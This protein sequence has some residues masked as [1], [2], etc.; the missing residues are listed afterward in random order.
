M[1][2][3]FLSLT[4]ELLTSGWLKHDPQ[5]T[6]AVQRTIKRF[7]SVVRASHV[8]PQKDD[9]SVR[10]YDIF[11]STTTQ[12]P[13]SVVDIN[14]FVRDETIV[15]PLRTGP[16]WNT[17][18]PPLDFQNFPDD[19]LP[20]P[21]H[22]HKLNFTF[23]LPLL[24]S[25]PPPSPGFAQRLHLEAI[26]AGLRVVCTAEDRSL[27]FYRIFNRVLDLPTRQILKSMMIDILDHNFN[28]LLLPPP[29]SD[30]DTSWAGGPASSPWLHASDVARYFRTIGVDLDQSQGI[31]SVK[32]HSGSLVARL[33]HTR[34]LDGRR[35]PV[36]RC[37][38]V[39]E[40]LGP[41]GHFPS[42]DRAFRYTTTSQCRK[43]AFAPDV[44]AN[45][46][47][48]NLQNCG[49]VH[50]SMDVSRLI[51]GK[52]FMGPLLF[53]IPKTRYSPGPSSVLFL[54]RCPIPVFTSPRSLKSFPMSFH[55][56]F[57]M[58]SLL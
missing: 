34:G 12:S 13:P 24:K 18:L 28:Q 9:Q 50:I 26:R 41:S 52:Y 19:L 7:I 46:L 31:V 32:V 45:E 8:P 6:K 21:H 48:P 47:A 51:Y 42:Q 57:P 37:P 11:D 36:Q 35:G 3:C 44:F 43:S 58:C 20:S 38:D 4:D 29:E 10:D 49:T 40:Q 2:T 14:A 55:T 5:A 56:L 54:V 1:N 30:I 53:L 33:L 22:N 39:W 25:L 16:Q 17:P 27:L 23:H 15:E